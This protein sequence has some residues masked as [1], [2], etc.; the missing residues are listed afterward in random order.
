M[1]LTAQLVTVWRARLEPYFD[2]LPSFNEALC[3]NHYEGDLKENATLKVLTMGEVAESAY[4]GGWTDG[5][6][7]A[8]STTSID[9]TLDQKRKIL[10]AVPDVNQYGSGSYQLLDQG[11]KRAAYA[12]S[13]RRDQYLATMHTNIT[14]NVYGSTGTPIVVGFDK[15][16]N[17]TLPSVALASLLELMGE[18]N[19]DMSKPQAVLPVWFGSYLY[20]EFSTK[21]TSGGDAAGTFAAV[22]GKMQGLANNA[23]GF[24]NLYLSNNVVNTAGAA[25]KVMASTPDV[26]ITYASVIDKLEGGRLQNDF[27]D[28]IKGLFYYGATVPFEK[29]MGLGTFNR[30][31]ARQ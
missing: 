24:S 31:T 27:S 17:E 3:N 30:G 18:S 8:L 11:S 23:G 22:P 28:Y 26:G 21:F 2:I 1:A 14:T 5:D 15:V 20:Q 25:Y 29:H 19:A 12:V 7:A 16:K 13:N 6:F 4:T 9:F 10:F